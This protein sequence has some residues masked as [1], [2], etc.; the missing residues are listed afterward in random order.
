MPNKTPICVVV[1][2]YLIAM[3]SMM[4]YTTGCTSSEASANEASSRYYTICGVLKDVEMWREDDDNTSTLLKFEDGRIQKSW[5]HY[6]NSPLFHV[7]KYN[8]ITISSDNGQMVSVRLKQGV[9]D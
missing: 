8:E 6:K 7:G 9:V 4:I 3:V 1:L 5:C 2:L